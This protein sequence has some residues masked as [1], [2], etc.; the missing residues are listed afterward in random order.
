MTD[1]PLAIVDTEATSLRP[2]LHDRGRRPWEIGVIRHDGGYRTATLVY[3]DVDLEHADHT[4]LQVGGYY[5]RHPQ[6][7]GIVPEIPDVAVH[8]LPEPKA[9]GALVE[10]LVHGATLIAANPD[11]DADGLTW[12]IH[13]TYPIEDSQPWHYHSVCVTCI[14]GAMAGMPLPYNSTE[15]SKW[16]GV[17]RHDPRFQPAHTALADALW[18]EAQWFALQAR[19]ATSGAL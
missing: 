1:Q 2:A 13:Q 7:T 11:Y 15:V 4:S 3:T 18:H 9:A 19:V 6:V 12:L 17:D 10:S 8:Y 5:E 16:M 14:G